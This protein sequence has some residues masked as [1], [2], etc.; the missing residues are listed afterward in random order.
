MIIRLYVSPETLW[1]SRDLNTCISYSGGLTSVYI[2]P[3]I[4]I[5]EKHLKWDY[6]ANGDNNFQSNTFRNISLLRTYLYVFKTM[7]TIQTWLSYMKI[8][9]RLFRGV[10]RI[11]LFVCIRDEFRFSSIFLTY[12]G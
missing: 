3:K 5:F 4:V 9:P 2:N 7:R 11:E 10:L 1:N 8:S 12:C 6:S